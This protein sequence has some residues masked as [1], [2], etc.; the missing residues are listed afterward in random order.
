VLNKRKL[1]A[2]NIDTSGVKL[3]ETNSNPE[4]VDRKPNDPSASI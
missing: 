3:Y 4:G 1:K 2:D